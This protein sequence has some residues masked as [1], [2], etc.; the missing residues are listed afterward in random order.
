MESADLQVRSG[1]SSELIQLIL[2]LRQVAPTPVTPVAS[3]CRSRWWT[4]ELNAFVAQSYYFHFEYAKTTYGYAILKYPA[5]SDSPPAQTAVL[6]D[7]FLPDGCPNSF[8]LGAV[9][10]TYVAAHCQS[11]GLSSLRVDF[12]SCEARSFLQVLL[13]TLLPV[14][15]VHNDAFVLGKHQLDVLAQCVAISP[16][17]YKGDAN[18]C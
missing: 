11:L 4:P 7:F 16:Q 17:Q 1:R 8:A 9:M 14:L 3:L 15:T 13:K 5:H 18:G 10:L 6:L 12:R 2:R